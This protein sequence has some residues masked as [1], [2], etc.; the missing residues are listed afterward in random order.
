VAIARRRHLAARRKG[1]RG[2]LMRTA[3]QRT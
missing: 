2:P 1:K 3:K